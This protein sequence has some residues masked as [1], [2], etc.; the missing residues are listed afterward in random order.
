MIL[1]RS[2]QPVAGGNE[3]RAKWL[4][5]LKDGLIAAGRRD[6]SDAVRDE[7][8]RVSY[9]GARA[10]TGGLIGHGGLRGGVR[11]REQRTDL[12]EVLSRSIYC[13]GI[14]VGHRGG[15]PGQQGRQSSAGSVGDLNEACQT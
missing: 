13:V 1:V 11:C 14:A 9:A 8:L 5:A 12:F 3:L 10:I 7:D 6:L 15:V 4:P 2:G